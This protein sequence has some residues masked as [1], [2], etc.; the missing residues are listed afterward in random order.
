MHLDA[1][2]EILMKGA[3]VELG[4]L[5]FARLCPEFLNYGQGKNKRIPLLRLSLNE[6]VN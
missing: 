4:K 3:A 5:C 6:T 2:T 1:A